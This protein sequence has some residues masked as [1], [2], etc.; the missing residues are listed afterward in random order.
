MRQVLRACHKAVWVIHPPYL[1]CIP[2][3]ARRV[4]TAHKVS[5]VCLYVSFY[6]CLFVK[7]QKHVFEDVF[8]CFYVCKS[9]T[10]CVR[11]NYTIWF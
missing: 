2:V 5:S 7:F 3:L 9:S 4:H 8:V 6:V 10:S 11:K 1:A